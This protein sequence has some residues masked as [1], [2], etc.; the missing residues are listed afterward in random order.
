MLVTEQ[1]KGVER[2]FKKLMKKMC[3]VKQLCIDFIF[4]IINTYL[5]FSDLYLKADRKRS[6]IN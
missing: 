6:V 1:E 4:T 5:S 3:I 2:V